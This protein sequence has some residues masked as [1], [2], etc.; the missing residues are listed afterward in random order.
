MLFRSDKTNIYYTKKNCR[1]CN[2]YKL[3]QVLNLNN[4]PPPNRLS[5]NFCE[6]LNFPLILN[7]CNECYHLQ[8]NGVL[9]P[10]IMYK[11]YSYLSGTSNTMKEYFKNFVNSLNITNLNLIN[12]NICQFASYNRI[13]TN[14]SNNTNI[15][16]IN[17]SKFFRR[18]SNALYSLL[19]S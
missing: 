11:N 16:I 18:Q 4:Q 10:I 14:K 2:S 17:N 13:Y 3:I 9:N 12:S 19:I 7:L 8:L 15:N 1:V 5:D 6:L